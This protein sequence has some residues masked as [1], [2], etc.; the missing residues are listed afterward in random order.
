MH[1]PQLIERDAEL[2][3]LRDLLARARG[4]EGSLALVEGPAGQGKTSLLRVLRREAADAGFEVLSATSGELERDFAYGVVR[5]LFE[6]VVHRGDD[7]LFTGAAALAEPLFDTQ[8][9][10][11][12][13]NDVSHPQLHGLFWM[14]A[15]LAEQRPLALVIDDAH[16]AD[17]P[18]L[19]FLDVLAR[20]I[21]D[22]PALLV[23]GARPGERPDDGLLDALAAAPSARVVAPGSLSDEGVAALLERALGAAPEE[24]FVRVCAQATRGNPFLLGE[25][26]RALAAAG[27]SGTAAEA[28]EAERAVPGN[29]TRLVAAR[30]RRLSPEA[31]AV[32]R[33][34]ALFG[35]R[36]SVAQLGELAALAPDAVREG[37]SVLVRAGLLEPT[38]LR[39]VHPLVRE[40]VVADLPTGDRSQWHR[41]AARIRASAGASEDEVA[42]HLALTDPEGDAWAARALTEAGLRALRAGVPDTA[43]RT[44]RRA[45][46][47][48]PEAAERPGVMLALGVA[49]MRAGEP[50]ALACLTEAAQTAA[51]AGVWDIH[52]RATGARAS[53][54]VMRERGREAVESL[55]AAVEATRGPAPEVAAELEDQLLD[56]LPFDTDL[57]PQYWAR[58]EGAADGD[59][60]TLLAHV[61]HERAAQ[62]APVAEVLDLAR[63]ALADGALGRQVDRGRTTPFWAIEALLVAEAAEE[64][65]VALAAVERNVRASGSRMMAGAL[66]FISGYWERMFGDLRRAEDQA[67]L[68][69]EFLQSAEAFSG[70]ATSQAVLA[71]TLLDRGDLGAAEQV[72]EQMPGAYSPGAGRATAIRGRLRF[73]QG[74]YEEALADLDHQLAFEERRGWRVTRREPT[75]AVKVRVL[76]ALGRDDEARALVDAEIDLALRRGAA[77][78]EAIARLARASLFEGDSG[79]DELRAAVRAAERSPLRQ[80]RAQAAFALGSALRRAGLRS[81]ARELLS[82]ARDLAHRSGATALEQ[83]AHDELVIAGARPRRVAVDGVE[84]LTA[85][86]RRVADLAASGL[87]NREIAEALFVTLKTVEVHLGHAYGKLGIK[88]RSQLAEALRGG[89]P[90]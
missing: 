61:A 18:S 11:D 44:L 35:E 21:E 3:V 5:Q 56:V 42:A 41:R 2:A 53:V 27:L 48:P 36:G 20:R 30:L 8:A 82:A 84:A 88:G 43:A 19:R 17:G 77:G 34:V 74:R 22:L 73:L 60:P 26:A 40:A 69:V 25:L 89:D 29:V 4:G 79:V 80:P 45:L 54:L 9:A 75:R 68:G 24:P 66:T 13:V 62:G 33:G 63:R 65:R 57:L 1:V 47:E 39:F 15:N 85:A 14:C 6:P 87:R 10:S 50:T 70:L 71:A 81:E 67:R 52:G 12:G 38:E 16:W 32:A 28:G 51:A 86:E 31:L 78:A 46:A 76:A 72:L 37:V 59:D 58:L 83:A 23:V 64:A 90:G 49:A 55:T 7:A